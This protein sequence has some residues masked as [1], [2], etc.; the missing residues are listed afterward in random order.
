MT[1]NQLA[2]LGPSALKTREGLSL[3]L[4]YAKHERIDTVEE[5]LLQVEIDCIILCDPW[6]NDVVALCE[7]LQIA[8][9]DFS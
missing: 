4:G 7:V 1:L 2:S 8:D 5:A 9:I 6:H 3:L